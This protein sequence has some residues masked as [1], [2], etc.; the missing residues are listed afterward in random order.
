MATSESGD[1]HVDLLDQGSQGIDEEV[2][3][4]RIG[5]G[6][7]AK[8][9]REGAGLELTQVLV[10]RPVEAEG[11]CELSLSCFLCNT[12]LN[13]LKTTTILIYNTTR[14]RREAERGRAGC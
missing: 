10:D 6:E 1:S 7:L 5:V 4:P 11:G 2:S 3:S 13:H 14:V 12:S 9:A 8:E